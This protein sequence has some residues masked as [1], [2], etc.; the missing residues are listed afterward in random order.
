[1]AISA[2]MRTSASGMEA[3]SNRLGTVAD[4]IANVNTTGYKRADTEFSSFIPNRATNEYISGSVTT[5]VRNAISEQGVFNATTSVTDLAINGDGFFVVSD[6]D[7][8]PFLTRAGSFVKNGDGE[9]VNAGGYFLLGYAL[10]EGDPSVV[11]NGIGGLERVTIS[12]LALQAAPSTLGVFSANVPAD[13]AIIPAANLPTANT[14]ASQFTAKTSLL[15]VSNLGREVSLDIYWAKTANETWEISV[16]DRAQADPTGGQFPYSSGPL[17]TDTITFDPVTG[18]LDPASPTTL[19]IPVPNGSPLVIDLAQ[20]SQLAT[21][22]TVIDA[23]VNGNAPSAVDRIEI[24]QQG[25]L[26]A[27]YENGSRVAT[28]HIPL[29]DVPSADNL[30]PETGDVYT[31]STSSGDMLIG[32]PGQGGLGILSSSSL[33]QSTVDLA[34]EL[35]KMIES[36]KHFS[37]NSKVFQTGA[38]LL[39]VIVNLKR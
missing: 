33:E 11:A 29:A 39:D 20:T 26:Y 12:D 2:I 31:T 34:T 27:I 23:Q 32:F 25:T 7:G 38:D 22:Y 4:N 8:S 13:A 35:V 24:D 19:T 16:Y 17:V 15:A 9:L 10:A 1:M 3:Q 37:V 18:A 28:F 36:E 21:E 6:N 30:T 5:H 14:A